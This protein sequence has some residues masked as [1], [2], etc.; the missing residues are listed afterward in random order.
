[1]TA[2]MQGKEAIEYADRHLRK[3]RTDPQTWTVEYEDPATGERWIMDYPDS[4]YHGGG[5][6]RLRRVSNSDK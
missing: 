2:E 5:S 4:G 3:V 6:P 1:M